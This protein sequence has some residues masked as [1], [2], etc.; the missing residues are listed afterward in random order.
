MAPRF[1]MYFK[2]VLAMVIDAI[3]INASVYLALYLRFDV[4]YI[5]RQYLQPYQHIAIYFTL[6]TI[7]LLWVTRIYHR[8]WQY[9]GSRDAQVLIGSLLGSVVFLDGYLL[10]DKA[11]HYPRGVYVLYV[12]FAMALVGGWRFL[13]RSYYDITWM[14]KSKAAPRVLIVGAGKAGQLVAQ[15]LA[16]HPEVG[17]AV[18]FLDDDTAKHGMQIGN[19]KVLG[20]TEQLRSLLRDHHVDQV[21]FAIPSASGKVL[22]PLVDQCR[23]LNVKTR[24]LPAINQMIG[25]QVLVNQIRDIQIE[26]LLQREP[27]VVDLAEIAGYITNRTVM[28]TGAGGTIGSELCRQVA[29]FNPRCL[30]LLGLDETSIFD[31]E[32]EM[33]ASYPEM[34]VAPVVA[35]L[36]DLG[37]I[38]HVMEQNRPEVIFH[39][40]AHKHV[41]LME[42]QPPEAIRNNV[43]GLWGFL[44]MAQKMHV[45]RFVFISTD[46]AVN[47]TSVYGTTKRIGEIL[48]A[49]Y[50]QNTHMRF[51]TVRFGNVL[52][53]RGSVLPTF[54]RQIAQGGPLTVTHPDMVRY[55]MTVAEACQLVVQAG[56]MGKGG[57]TFVLDMGEPIKIMDLATNLIRLSGLTPGVDVDI[58][59]TGLRP[60]EKLYEEPLTPEDQTKATKNSRIFIHTG[61]VPNARRLLPLLEEL[62][63]AGRRADE[64]RIRRL[65]KEIVPEYQPQ[66]SNVAA[67]PG[68]G[69]STTG[70]EARAH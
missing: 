35:D 33:R 11:A 4:P 61:D 18:G 1:R 45:E 36:R 56:A 19:L 29:R 16:R 66:N 48:G 31:I 6:T 69:L 41:P 63:E 13:I 65:L 67:L 57:E 25:G 10:L 70:G 9:A 62:V 12:L 34:R 22:R 40:A 39:A 14:P 15:E 55:F 43:E 58:V 2:I 30:V 46:K 54:Q 38:Q 44:D 51:V 68:M 3:M 64:P 52:G 50:A 20:T 5:P 24:L 26:D 28:V 23:D 53:S 42:I 27:A 17:Q 7:L 32:Q 21:L 49:I 59:F 37:R 8:M 47:P 60:G